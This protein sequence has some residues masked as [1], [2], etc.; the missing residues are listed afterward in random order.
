MDRMQI[1]FLHSDKSYLQ[2]LRHMP[3][4]LRIEIYTEARIE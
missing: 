4:L 2:I 1:H 3:G